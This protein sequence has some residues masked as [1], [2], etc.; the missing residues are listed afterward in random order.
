MTDEELVDFFAM[1]Q[2]IPG[3]I[4]GNIAV[5]AGYKAKGVAGA[6]AAISGIILPAFICIITLANILTGITQ[7]PI[8]QNAFEGI[9]VSVVVLIL[10]TIKDLWKDSVNS[11]FTY[12]LFIIIFGALLILPISPAIIIILAGVTALLHGKIKGV[13]N[14]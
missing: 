14:A 5:C 2:C 6:I 1:S 4:A 9:R 3:I 12:I 10:V 7:Y 13:K 8:V 11:L